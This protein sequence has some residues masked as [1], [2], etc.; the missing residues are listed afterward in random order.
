MLLALLTGCGSTKSYTAT[1]QLLMSDAVDATVAK[2]DFAPLAAR[3]VYLDTTYLKTQKGSLLID[4]DYVISSLRQQM[5]SSGVYLVETREEADLIA[6]ARIGALGLDGHNVTYGLPASSALAS[7]SSVFTN[8]PVLPAIPEISLARREAKSGAAKIAV[9]AYQRESR[10]PFWQ[11]GIARSSSSAQDTWILGAGPW[12]RGT[13]Y[14]G[15]QFAGRKL[16]ATD[17][18][19]SK[20][21]TPVTDEQFRQSQAFD[22][23]QRN[24]LF[25]LP[26]EATANHETDVVA[27]SAE[28]DGQPAADNASKA[29]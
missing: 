26:S 25:S 4:S 22:A 6:E 28:G 27:A 1:D 16:M 10:Q 13:I 2:I 19:K 3:K 9:F 21:G 18:I 12:Q 14:E 20:E 17:L 15:T 11:S 29:P 24:R 7:A 5:V 8:T 23:Y